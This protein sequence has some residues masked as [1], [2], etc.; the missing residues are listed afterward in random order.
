MLL[1]IFVYT[2]CLKKRPTFKLSVIL[3]DL[4]KIFA[5]LE[6]VWNLLQNPYDIM[7]LTLGML[8]AAL[9]WDIKVYNFCRYGRKHKQIAF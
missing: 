2:L 8:L 7:H 6:S 3:L 1:F 9:P 5:L 4:N